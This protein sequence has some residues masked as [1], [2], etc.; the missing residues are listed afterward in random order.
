MAWQS[1]DDA[2]NLRR[3]SQRAPD[4]GHG[5]AFNAA[6]NGAMRLTTQSILG[7]SLISFPLGTQALIRRWRGTPYDGI[8]A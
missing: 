8:V 2:A 7:K 4:P 1:L 3:R 5:N 6:S